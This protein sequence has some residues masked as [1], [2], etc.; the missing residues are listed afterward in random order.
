MNFSGE[1]KKSTVV[2]ND[3]VYFTSSY[4]V[5]SSAGAYTEVI[6][7]HKT[8]GAGFYLSGSSLGGKVITPGGTLQVE[9]MAVNEIMPITVVAASASN[10]TTH[11]V[12]LER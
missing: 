11:I 6:N 4:A 3:L 9:G 2:G 1:Y 8:T 12:V 10:A 7:L 5:T